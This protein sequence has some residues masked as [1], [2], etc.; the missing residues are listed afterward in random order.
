MKKSSPKRITRIF[1]PT[2]SHYSI[3]YLF[4]FMAIL[5]SL[6]LTSFGAYKLNKYL[7]QF[8][9]RTLFW[10]MGRRVIVKNKNYIEPDKTYLAVMNH[11]SLFDIPAI[12]T[13]IPHGSWVGRDKLLNIPIFG[14][15]LR[16]AN[17]I[18][19]NPASWR[20]SLEAIKLAT[21]KTSKGM[22]VLIFPEGTRTNDGS[23]QNFKK[24]FVKI[25]RETGVD[26]LPITING[27]YT[28]KSKHQKHINTSEKLEII[29]N[30][31]VH[32]K[33]L[34]VLTDNDVIAKVKGIIE[35]SY[36]T[37]NGD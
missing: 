20:Q 37:A 34:T 5:N 28:W 29:I 24:G 15:F 17:Y 6:L 30:K 25:M 35:S 26:I 4:T 13:F 31:P 3:H 16:R 9:A 2:A 32:A 36:Y 18:P 12:M 7:T 22:A 8:W 33:E 11:S 10:S 1:L 27:L 14:S 19:I 23:I 21:D